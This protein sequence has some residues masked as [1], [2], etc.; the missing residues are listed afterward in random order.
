MRSGAAGVYTELIMKKQ[1]KRNVNV[2]NIYLYMFGALAHLTCIHIHIQMHF[3]PYPC[4][5]H[6]RCINADRTVSIVSPHPIAAGIVFNVFAI[7]L[8]DSDAVLSQGFFHGYTPVVGVMILNHALSGIAVSMVMKFADNIVKVYS[9]SVAM[10]LTTLV[11]IPLF[12]FQ[13]TLPFVL[14]TSVVSV[15]VYL[16][17]Q[18]KK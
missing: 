11:S 2:Q 5:V 10:I 17:Y 1:P 15:A 14:G 18:S 16:H 7:F 4:R 6:I 8:Y 9:T 3:T 12:G 13:L